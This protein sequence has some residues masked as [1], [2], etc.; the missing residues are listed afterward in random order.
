MVKG[1]W[2]GVMGYRLGVR[3]YGLDCGYPRKVYPRRERPV[4]KRRM[5]RVAGAKLGWL[6]TRK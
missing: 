4:E 1:Y 6:E 2:L 3:G 5:V